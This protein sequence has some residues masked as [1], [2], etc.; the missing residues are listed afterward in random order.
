MTG[1]APKAALRSL[2][3]MDPITRRSLLLAASVAPLGAV[4]AT[5]VKATSP[6]GAVSILL[7]LTAEGRPVY[8]VNWRDHP[9][10][11]ESRLG[12]LEASCTVRR[13]A[14]RRVNT[15]WT[16][17]YGECATIPDAY[18]EI[19]VTLASDSSRFDVILRAYNEG[20][21]FRF[22]IPQDSTID[23]E[24]TGFRFPEGSLAWEEHGTEGEYSRVPV[25]QVKARCEWPL[26]VELPAGAGFACLTEAALD[27]YPRMLLS[28]SAQ[29]L[30]ADL[31]GP[32]QITAPFESPWRVIVL[33]QRPGDLLERNYLV[34][35]L[36]PPAIGDYSWAK[37]GKAIREVTLSTAGGK[38]CVDFAVKYGLQYIE[39]DA[40]WY[41]AEE[42]PAS[43][44][45]RVSLDPRRVGKIRNHGGLDLPQ[46]IQYARERSIGVLLY[47]NHLALERQIDELLPLYKG[48]GVAGIKF[49]FVNVGPQQ[50]TTWLMEAVR[51][52]AR[53]GLVVDI[54][55]G[56][57]PTGFSRTFP[58][59]LTQEGVRGNEH[60]PTARHNST[61]PYTRF[62]AGAADC[63]VCYY[64]DRIRTTR[65]HQLAI[66]VV[67]YSP[68]QF[69]FWYDTPGASHDEPE[70]EFFRAVPTVWDE[71]RVLAGE[72][73]EFIIVARR[74]GGEWFLGGITNENER[75]VPVPL[76]MLRRGRKYRAAIYQ[77]QPPSRTAVSIRRWSA[78]ASEVLEASLAPS[79]GFAVHLVPE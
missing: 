27:R 72:I 9:V 62:V 2:T 53:H 56:Y 21:A 76:T 58:N 20:V 32:A 28:P 13:T 1:T 74:K 23:R 19:T 54:H 25:E 40:G 18:S 44:A 10:I 65:A 7:R 51:K 5:P 38:A 46:V 17:V 64:T 22:R 73:G 71:T 34:L 15:S 55:D 3:N 11:L 50:W 39:Y 60:M 47:V 61:L 45:R 37:P 16:P 48:W 33:G 29:G 63:T 14:R 43:D 41:G 8:Q 35:N 79:G 12:W 42:D 70:L 59:L 30:M 77:D 69:L 57:R 49:G 67:F 6:D 26:T 66:S 68:L 78:T 4:D 31:T 24:L 52:C 36:N 75:R